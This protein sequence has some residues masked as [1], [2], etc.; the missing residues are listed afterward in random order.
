MAANNVTV[1]VNSLATNVTVWQSNFTMTTLDPQ[2]Q[3]LQNLAF[4]TWGVGQAALWLSA[5]S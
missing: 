4:N 1:W 5:N 2:T 3:A